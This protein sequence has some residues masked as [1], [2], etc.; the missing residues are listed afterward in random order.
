MKDIKTKESKRDIKTLDRAAGLAKV[1]RNA[2]VRTKDQIQNLSDDGQITPDEYAEDKVKYMT[3]AVA[4]DTG[5]AAKKTVQKTYDGGKRLYKEIRR[6]RK[7]TSNI[8]R[9]AR[10]TEK[11]TAKTLQKSIKTGRRTVKTAL[12]PA[13]KSGCHVSS[14]VC[15]SSGTAQKQCSSAPRPAARFRVNTEASAAFSLYSGAAKLPQGTLWPLQAAVTPVPMLYSC[16]RV[17]RPRL[18]R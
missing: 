3:E 14:R 8:K 15:Q 13:A 5:K 1:T 17:R 7:E 11:A 6:A 18:C 10:S 16:S 9:T 2:T 4:E 12:R